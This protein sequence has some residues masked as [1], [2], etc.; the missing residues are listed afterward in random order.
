MFPFDAKSPL[1]SKFFLNFNIQ[2]LSISVFPGPM[3]EARNFVFPDKYVK[4]DIPPIFTIKIFL[5]F[6]ENIDL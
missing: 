3:S 1:L 2:T 5:P 4:F 6:L